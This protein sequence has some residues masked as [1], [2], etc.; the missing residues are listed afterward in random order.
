MAQKANLITIR[1]TI[2][3]ELVVQNTKLWVIFFK[4]LDNISRLFFLKGILLTQNYLGLDNN[5]I[6][7]N[8]FL[9]YQNIRISLYRTKMAHL[10]YNQ[11]LF[12]VVNKS[13][14][15]VLKK[16]AARYFYNTYIFN[17]K[18]LNVLVNKQIS[19]FLYKKLKKFVSSIFSRRYNLFI[20][21]LKITSLFLKEKITLTF[22]IKIWS[23]IFKN[24]S[25]R[26]HTKFLAFV[27]TVFLLLLELPSSIKITEQFLGLKFLIAGRFRGK[28]RG[29]TKLIA[30]GCVPTQSLAKKVQ[31]ASCHS[32]TIYGTFGLK[33]WVYQ[34]K[35][36]HEISTGKT[37]I[38][39][40]SKRKIF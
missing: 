15:S 36:K 12:N 30:L 34:K 3:T 29:S 17:L 9:F 39:K 7:F 31:F 11:H 8:F 14:L 6:I 33:M 5:I 21:F 40:I 28:N 4:F 24:I 20:D 38:Q 27:K 13:L 16:Y 25:K 32:Y 37:K 1:K 35:I 26:L 22:Y 23:R 18:N 10:K 2:N 19:I